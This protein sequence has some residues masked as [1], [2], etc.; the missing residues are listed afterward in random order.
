MYALFGIYGGEVLTGYEAFINVVHTE[1]RDR[2]YRELTGAVE[3]H[4]VYD[5][6]IGWSDNSIH[7]IA[8]RAK[9]MFEDG[10]RVSM[11]GTCW[12]ITE[13]KRMDKVKSE[14]VST[15]SHELRTPL[16]S[17]AG[18][19]GLVVSGSVGELPERVK[20]LLDIAYKNS[21]R[22]KLLINDLLDMEKL[23]ASKLQFTCET[24]PLMPLVEQAVEENKNYAEQYKVRYVIKN[25]KKNV[26]I[27]VEQMRFLQ[28]MHHFLSNA[29]KFFKIPK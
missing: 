28:F 3:H 5:R 13:R 21:Q 26:R 14:F 12:D 6:S 17:I 16:T 25:I 27:N 1:D 22:L 7:Y 11:I 20:Q 4:K 19:L 10:E 24:Q 29:A 8:S 15:V 18:A 23:L 9:I 2:V